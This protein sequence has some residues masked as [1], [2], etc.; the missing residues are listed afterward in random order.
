MSNSPRIHPTTWRWNLGNEGNKSTSLSWRSVAESSNFIGSSLVQDAKLTMFILQYPFKDFF[1]SSY[2]RTLCQIQMAYLINVMKITRRSRFRCLPV[3]SLANTF[4]HE[5]AEIWTSWN[6]YW[7]S[8]D[9]TPKADHFHAKALHGWGQ[10]LERFAWY[11][12]CHLTKIEHGK[13]S[14]SIML[15][16]TQLHMLLQ[17]FLHPCWVGLLQSCSNFSKWYF[18]IKYEKPRKRKM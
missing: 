17:T 6:T 1:F 2:L 16:L 5:Q 12:E 3:S 18:K 4:D 7:K 13:C 8:R 14:G 11:W 10:T 15:T 9:N